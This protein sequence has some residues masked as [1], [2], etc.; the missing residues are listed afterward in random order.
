MENHDKLEEMLSQYNDKPDFPGQDAVW[1]RIKNGETRR[2]RSRSV[3]LRPVLLTLLVLTL[4]STTVFASQL[5][6]QF[7]HGGISVA[8]YD[9]LVSSYDGERIT[10]IS[11]FAG[12]ER[13]VELTEEELAG[14]PE[15]AHPEFSYIEEVQAVLPF[16]IRVPGKPEGFAFSH[17][18]ARQ[19][20][21]GRYDQSVR[22]HYNSENG[23]GKMI[24][25]SQDYVGANGK[26]DIQVEQSSN[27]LFALEIN[28]QEAVYVGAIRALIWV[29]EG[30]AYTA[31]G[32]F[33]DAMALVNALYN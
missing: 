14:F 1:S 15:T 22:L 13:L 9:K 17:T 12:Q 20:V 16:T 3:R 23:D 32:D 2:I 7:T 11:L 27:A 31:S 26:L 4:L 6:R 8:E 24:S 10:S 28:G 5:I 18:V 33:E 21:S 25:L 30:I 29:D 19:F